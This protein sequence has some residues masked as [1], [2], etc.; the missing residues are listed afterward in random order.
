MQQALCGDDLLLEPK[1]PGREAP[2]AK[3]ITEGA[4]QGIDRTCQV[5]NMS[6][7]ENIKLVREVAAN[8]YSSDPNIQ[9]VFGELEIYNSGDGGRRVRL[10]P[11]GEQQCKAEVSRDKAEQQAQKDGT[12]GPQQFAETKGKLQDAG[13]DIHDPG[14]AAKEF[15]KLS[16]KQREQMATDIET[17]KDQYP[18][19]YIVRDANGKPSLENVGQAE[20][21]KSLNKEFA[22]AGERR[23][24]ETAERLQQ[25]RDHPEL[26]AHRLEEMA[27]KASKGD[28]RAESEYRHAID[29]LKKLPP[30]IQQKI[31]E[32]MVKDPTVETQVRAGTEI[33]QDPGGKHEVKVR[34]DQTYE[35]QAEVARAEHMR[36]LRDLASRGGVNEGQ[37]RINQELN[38]RE[39]GR[40]VLLPA[41]EKQW[42][43][44]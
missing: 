6:D 41:S 4:K 43:D 8:K 33:I 11:H 37:I 25:M 30:D 18:N 44:Y 38:D 21:N 24:R 28:S 16:P 36:H 35:Q 42:F 34:T 26:S 2:T 9:K 32:A 5:P 31:I 13:R 17:H 1:M 23:E 14:N 7:P 15:N 20:V 27:Q 39:A 40:I 22:A 12:L 10:T 3:D 29:D 19:L